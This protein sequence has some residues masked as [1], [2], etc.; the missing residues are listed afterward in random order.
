MIESYL[1]LIGTTARVTQEHEILL[2]VQ[3]DAA[4]RARPRHATRVAA[5]WSSRPSGSPRASRPPR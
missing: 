5:R 3:V 4:P 2:A 1:E